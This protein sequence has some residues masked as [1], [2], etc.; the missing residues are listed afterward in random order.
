MDLQRKELR[1]EYWRKKYDNPQWGDDIHFALFPKK[2]INKDGF[3]RGLRINTTQT[4]QDLQEL[5]SI[6]RL[7]TGVRVLDFGCGSGDLLLKFA[8]TMPNVYGLGIDIADTAIAR[9]NKHVQPEN[10]DLQFRVGDIGTLRALTDEFD[11]IVC[12]DMYY[13]LDTCEQEV[14]LERCAALLRPGGVLYIA[15]L[16]IEV[17]SV[18]TVREPLLDRQYAG[19]PITWAV[20]ANDKQRWSITDQAERVGF[21]LHKEVVEV[22]AVA[23]SY[24]A[25]CDLADAPT[26]RAFESLSRLARGNVN[27][28]PC[29]P[30]VRLFFT[31]HWPYRL[32]STSIGIRVD[33]PLII[34]KKLLLRP[35]SWVLP[36]GEWSLVLGRSGVGKTTLLNILSGFAHFPGVERIGGTGVTKFLLDQ[37]P[38]LIE[39][40]NVDDNISL[41]ARS[42]K[43]ADEI[44]ETLGFD[45]SLRSRKAD[46]KLSGGEWQRVALG[47]AI[48]ARPDILFMDEPG[49]GIDR[50]RKY[51][52][53][54]TIW[55]NLG[56][57]TNGKRATVVCVDHEFVQIESFFTHIFEMLHGSL[58]CLKP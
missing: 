57:V 35:E 41:F 6:Y 11:I 52:F 26:K 16:A 36:V 49:T 9:A 23:D 46:P 39:E 54:S 24:A 44:M 22:D 38:V 55:E 10:A 19:E 27:Y 42:R 30:Y 25:A 47:Q 37:R 51:Q 5:A 28:R 34:G 13:T 53:F 20:D 1:T 29:I 7:S 33:R 32:K 50:V 43:D 21:E 14:F 56:K 45:H 3:L 4:C 15:D 2:E 48:A 58:I 17:S 8:A 40:L 31:R 18:D 12:R